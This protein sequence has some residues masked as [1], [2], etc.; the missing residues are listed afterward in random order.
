[1]ETLFNFIKEYSR[2]NN[3]PPTKEA[4]LNK[5]KLTEEELNDK[6]NVLQQQGKIKLSIR[7]K[8]NESVNI[9]N[10]VVIQKTKKFTN[11]K[12]FNVF[13]IKL[14]MSVVSLLTTI[15][16]IYYTFIWFQNSTQWYWAI[17]WAISMVLCSIGSF[18]LIVFYN[19][20]KFYGMRNLFLFIFCVVLLMS[21]STSIAGQLNLTRLKIRKKQL[22]NVAQNNYIILYRDYEKQ[23]EDIQIDIDAKRKEIV[24]LQGIIEQIKDKNVSGKEYKHTNNLIYKKNLTLIQLKKR[25]DEFML[26]KQKLLKDNL[27]V[28]V[29]EDQIDFFVW[30]SQ[31]VKVNAE[32]LR[33]IQFILLAIFIDVVAPVSFMIILF[34]EYDKRKKGYL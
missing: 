5:F 10:K 27:Q 17:I 23:I 34:L 2:Q 4:L 14:M 7:E 8:Q 6:L 24:V 26:N 12:K 3:R 29:T 20:S 19:R 22:T 30:L 9:E 32:I 13:V 1:M 33:L 18:E 31:I 11:N 16:S 25:R 15:M 21:M 28:T